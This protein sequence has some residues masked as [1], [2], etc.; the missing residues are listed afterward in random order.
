LAKAGLA[1]LDGTSAG[2]KNRKKKALT[3]ANEATKEALVK[4]PDPKSEAKEAEEAPEVTED[5]MRA[6]FQV[7]LM[8]AKQAQKIAKAAMTAA[9]SK[10]FAFYSNLLSPENKYTLNKIAGKQTE[11]DPFVNLQGISLEGQRGMSRKS[12]N[13]CLTFHILT[14][15]PINAAEQEK[16][17]VT[18]VLKKPQRINVRQFVGHVEQLNAY[19]AQMP[20]FYYSPHTNVSTKP[21]NVPFTEAELGAHVLRMCPLQWQDQYN[22]NKKGMMLM[23]MHLLLTSLEAIKRVCTYKKGKLESSEKSSHKSKKGKKRPGTN[24]TVRI[25]KKVRFE[26]HCNL[27]K[28][29]GGAYTTHNTRDCHRFEK[30]GKEKSNFHAAKK[31]RKNGNPVN[32]NFAQ[33]TKKIGKLKK[34]LNKSGKIGKKRCYKDSNSDSK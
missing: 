16:Y 20:C 4:V 31:G 29:H 1:L 7:D 3:K 15:F 8:K 27:C 23:D 24:S 28:K 25:P 6:G 26:K 2:K 11:N 9:A 18:N 22:M 10:T 17:Y 19:I 14:A 21:E 33:L 30:D 12:F 13:N 34:A 32:H 5:T